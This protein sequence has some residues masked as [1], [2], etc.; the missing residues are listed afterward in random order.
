MREK[1][2]DILLDEIQKMLNYSCILYASFSYP[3]GAERRK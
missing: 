2:L 1:L 3:R